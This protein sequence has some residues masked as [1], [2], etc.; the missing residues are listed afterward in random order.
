LVLELV[1]VAVAV[2]V[3]LGGSTELAAV[4]VAVAVVMLTLARV[5]R[6]WL[7]EWVRVWMAFRRRRGAYGVPHHGIDPQL[8]PLVELIPGLG[9]GTA[10]GLRNESMGVIHDGVAWTAVVAVEA[11]EGR[12]D[13][14]DQHGPDAIPIGPLADLVT[15]A[16]LRLAS[17]QALVQ[18]VP[19]PSV[20]HS[21]EVDHC[22]ASYRQLHPTEIPSARTAL[23]A[24]RLDP[25]VCADALTVRGGS[26][27]VVHR[28]LRRFAHRVIDVLDEAGYRA[29]LLPKGDI[30]AVLA[31]SAGIQLL[32]FPD[33]GWRTL[34]TWTEQFSDGTAHVT[35]WLRDWPPTGITEL[36]RA[37]CAVRTLFTTVSLTIT[38]DDRPGREAAVV[39]ALVRVTTGPDDAAVASAEAVRAAR[40]TGAV[41]VPL[42]GAQW[43]GLLATI[44][45]GGGSLAPALNVRPHSF[46]NS[47]I[48]ELAVP[49][50]QSGMVVGVWSDGVP[51]VVPM[52]REAPT[53]VGVVAAEHVALILAGRAI[54][55]GARVDVVTSR[56]EVWMPLAQA[57]PPGD[58]VAIHPPGAATPPPGTS[59]RPSLVIDD[60]SDA[61]D[62]S[63]AQASRADLGA[64]QTALTLRRH[65]SVETVSAM[66][67]YQLMF[68]Q[69]V[70]AET[71]QLARLARN[72]SDANARMLSMM[73]DG[74][75]G[76]ATGSDL[77]VISLAATTVER[78]LFP[79]V[80]PAWSRSA[81]GLNHPAS[82]SVEIPEGSWGPH[83]TPHSTSGGGPAG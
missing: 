58:W 33:D 52:F 62:A 38:P 5:R 46:A 64:W 15:S 37:L 73:P 21:A 69:R 67:A 10:I 16:D 66:S 30:Q 32:A 47:S 78:A 70:S 25:A 1:A 27:E 3:V 63:D 31:G 42:R 4:G 51:A 9:I 40:A 36:L 13:R 81:A 50:E 72:L 35:H 57:A 26:V 79:A 17:V 34:E 74:C 56:P 43:P 28:A 23:I 61:S 8:A 59:V 68:F 60:A 22:A 80:E 11:D 24:L 53:H 6:R 75:V 14:A 65:V 20:F 7:Y 29:R 45:L 71:A 41:L 49:F 19:A 2:G 39:T 12:A 54:A 77:V 44:P 48:N 76:V 82:A 18:L 55:V 83:S